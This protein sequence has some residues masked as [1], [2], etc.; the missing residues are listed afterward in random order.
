LGDP[1]DADDPD[2]EDTTVADSLQRRSVYHQMA[3]YCGKPGSIA[4]RWSWEQVRAIVDEIDEPAAKSF[5][6]FCATGYSED[7]E[8]KAVLDSNGGRLRDVLDIHEDYG[9]DFESCLAG[10]K[11]ADMEKS[12]GNLDL[13][14]AYTAQGYMLYRG[15][16]VRVQKR[17][18][19]RA[20]LEARAEIRMVKATFAAL[21][22]P[23]SSTAKML[24]DRLRAQEIVLQ[25]SPDDKLT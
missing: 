7:S 11:K 23:G 24:E 12:H 2:P 19:D 17:Q 21:A 13:L 18:K 10:F 6:V 22:E 25:K 9:L 16:L 15:R 8:L 1:Q 3:V 20:E 4:R 14:V 5:A